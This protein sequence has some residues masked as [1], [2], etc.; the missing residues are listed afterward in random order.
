M[1][2]RRKFLLCPV[3]AL[4][5]LLLCAC[6]AGDDQIAQLEAQL[7]DAQAQ[8]ADIQ[9]QAVDAQARA[10]EAEAEAE[11][12]QA[13]LNASLEKLAQSK[14]EWTAERDVLNARLELIYPY[15]DRDMCDQIVRDAYE[16][17]K[18]ELLLSAY[19]AQGLDSIFAEYTGEAIV[20]YPQDASVTTAH[21]DNAYYWEGNAS[22]ETAAR[23]L[24]EIMLEDVRNNTDLPF[25]LEGYRVE[26]Q[27]LCSYDDMLLQ[28]QDFVWNEGS[29]PEGIPERLEQL[30][31]IWSE[32]E[33]GDVQASLR[34]E[35][36]SYALDENT[37]LFLPNFYVKYTGF[38]DVYK[39]TE[40]TPEMVDENG[41]L[42]GQ[43]Q[44]SEEM[45]MYV[46][47]RNGNVWRLQS[48]DALVRLDKALR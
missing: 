27:T 37:W 17:R 48:C 38:Y 1:K 44:G 26:E 18:D 23:K 2:T 14:E 16:Q 19:L 21:V 43:G 12:L 9:A 40:L 7:A 47:I 15:V 29:A 46:L 11:E 42:F 22:P 4:I 31:P 28:W 45:Y 20:G 13:Q 8:A 5:L 33:Q 32:D 30:F 35:G 24:V 3:I 25:N 10:E 41:Y 36:L 6:G 39:D 34:S